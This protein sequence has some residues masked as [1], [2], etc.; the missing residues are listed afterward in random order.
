MACV[1]QKKVL[2]TMRRLSSGYIMGLPLFMSI[3]TLHYSARNLPS[4]TRQGLQ[5]RRARL[6][7]A[8]AAPLADLHLETALRHR[9]NVLVQRST[10]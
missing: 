4:P 6:L 3:I 5:G 7:F 10:R 9:T 8:Q 2:M 1:A